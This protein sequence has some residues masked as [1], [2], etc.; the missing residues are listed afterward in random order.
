MAELDFAKLHPETIAVHADGPAL[1]ESAGRRNQYR[2]AS[3]AHIQ[4][5]F[6]T[7]EGGVPLADLAMEI[8]IA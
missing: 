7:P 5:L 1:R 8:W 6:V 3:A 2:A 4:Q